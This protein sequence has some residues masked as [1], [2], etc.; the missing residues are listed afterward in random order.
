VVATDA[1]D[2]R[3]TALVRAVAA[4]CAKIAEDTCEVYAEDEGIAMDTYATN[5]AAAI[6]S[7]FGLAEEPP[8]R[9]YGL[10]T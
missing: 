3:L 2:A 7:R 4:E 1:T 5:T 9:V 8:K 6:R 10:G